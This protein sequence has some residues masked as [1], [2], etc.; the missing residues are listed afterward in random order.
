MALSAAAYEDITDRRSSTALDVADI[1]ELF[2]LG[3]ARDRDQRVLR[4]LAVA[5]RARGRSAPTPGPPGSA[6]PGSGIAI[7]LDT[8]C[9]R[10]WPRRAADRACARAA[11]WAS[12]TTSSPPIRRS[13]RRSAV[14]GPGHGQRL[15]RDNL[16]YFSQVHGGAD[17]TVDQTFTLTR[18]PVLR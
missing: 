5:A 7:S 15:S 10:D 3:T 8:L 1:G 6:A 2:A 12:T 16:M 18:S 13:G 4:P 17:L 11:T 9:Y 14:A